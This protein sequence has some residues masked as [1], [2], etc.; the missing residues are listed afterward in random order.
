LSRWVACKFSNRWAETGKATM[1][2]EIFGFDEIRPITIKV[3]GVGGGGCNAVRA[4]VESGL[5]G[6]HFILANTDFH[7][8]D[9]NGSTTR[10][11]LG[12][13]LTKGLGAGADPATG[14]KAAEESLAA[15]VEQIQ[16]ADMLFITAG[17]GG[18]T[19]T[20][21]APVIGM[22]AKELGILTVGVVTMPFV[23]E[24]KRRARQA[25]KGLLD[26]QEFVNSHI[27]I[28]ND[29]LASLTRE[30]PM[31]QAFEPANKILCNAV[32]SIVEIIQTTGLINVDFA[33]V[34]NVLSHRGRVLMGSGNATGMNR[35]EK[36][37]AEAICSPL[38]KG[39][40]LDGAKGILVNI[41]GSSDITMDEFDRITDLIHQKIHEE[42][43]VFAGL[44]IDEIMDES[45][46]ITVI[47]SG[48]ESNHPT[49]SSSP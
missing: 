3:L 27:V 45:L 10:I 16:G 20:G 12:E 44:V 38:L 9:T 49:L 13:K 36:A 31:E 5:E 39:Y 43:E 8:S 23:F 28:S 42:A 11:Q 46:R 40:S 4:M 14:R 29:Q 30:L 21:A 35:A 25:E 6:V 22:A 24:G 48:L 18:G 17:M 37:L 47:A 19:G 7:S 2:R 34:K 41:V 33:D 15:I 26:L 32:Q 1:E